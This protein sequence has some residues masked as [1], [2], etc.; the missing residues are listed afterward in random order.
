V[1][2]AVG[3]VASRA[4]L[5]REVFRM[6]RTANMIANEKVAKKKVANIKKE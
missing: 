4:P 2:R 3:C 1:K 5:W 6:P